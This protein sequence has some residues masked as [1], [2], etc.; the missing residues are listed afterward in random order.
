MNELSSVSSFYGSDVNRDWSS[1][2]T[3]NHFKDVISRKFFNLSF[4]HSR[5]SQGKRIYF[6]LFSEIATVVKL[7][8]VMLAAIASSKR[9]FS[10]S[11]RIKNYLR[12]T[13]TQKRLNNLMLLSVYKEDVDNIIIIDIANEFFAGNPHRLWKFRHLSNANLTKSSVV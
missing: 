10:A 8:L 9:S 1:R 4:I 11:R 13:M 6:N 12:S 3:A 7:L 5:L 2:N